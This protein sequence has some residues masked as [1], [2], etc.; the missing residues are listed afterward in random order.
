MRIAFVELSNFRK[1]KATRIEF[2]VRQTLFVGAN[3]SGK[4]S[5]MT[6]LRLFLKERG[7]FTTKDVTLSNWRNINALGDAWLKLSPNEEPNLQSL[8]TFLPA[9]DVWLEVKNA[10]LH[11]VAHLLPSLDWNGGLIGVRLRLEPD[12]IEKLV[13]EYRDARQKAE[14]QL[15][16][17]KKKHGDA[18]QDFEL[19]PR[20]LHDFFE[21]RFSILNLKAYPLDPNAV[22]KP[23]ADNI[24]LP[25]SLPPLAQALDGNPLSHLIHIR[26][27]NAQRGF[28]DASSFSRGDEEISQSSEGGKNRLSEQLRGFYKRHLDPTNDPSDEDVSALGAFHRAQKTFDE[29]L[30]QGFQS[31]IGELEKLG[32]PGLTNPKLTIVTRIT[33][34]N[35]LNHPSAVQYALNDC[36]HNDGHPNKLPEDYNGLGFQNL[37][38]MVFRLIRFRSDWMQVGKLQQTSAILDRGVI[39]P[40]QLV[41]VEE[42]E[43][44]LH[45]QVQ[46][47]FARKA[48]EVLRNH[49]DLGEHTTFHT[50]LIVSTHSSHIAHEVDFGCLRYF[51]RLPAIDLMAVPNAV[52]ANLSTVFGDGSDTDRFVARY[53]RTTHCDLFFADGVILIEGT[54]ERM[55]VPQFIRKGYPVLSEHYVSILEIGGSHAH[56]LRPLIELL[57][58]PT[59]IITDLD[60]ISVDERKSVR[61][62]LGTK[63]QTANSVLKTWLPGIENLDELL[64]AEANRTKVG[65]GHGIVH[66]AFQR[67]VDVEFPNGT[68]TKGVIPSTFE[69]AFVLTNLE[70][71][72]NLKG[73]D[74]KDAVSMTKGFLKFVSEAKTLGELHEK[75]FEILQKKSADKAGFALDLLTLPK[76][77]EL[78]PP[79]YIS[80]GLAWLEK[81]M[82]VV[83]DVPRKLEKKREND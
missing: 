40:L 23:E 29:K 38:S 59:L 8:I 46:Q 16:G 18:A 1:L 70:S 74:L 49:S 7:G 14:V 78:L 75:L 27:I 67:P 82:Q 24:A 61:P 36:K 79:L 73:D 35:V 66:V 3:N 47:V 41:L 34:N 64:G 54:A 5:A 68:T 19:W 37:I 39:E 42:P 33:P 55:L 31:A 63:Q 80:E 51:K 17:Y 56:R 48:Y 77:E 43:A 76:L 21:K 32:Y 65:E 9:L 2:A 53:L 13:S 4:T 15:A 11:H 62:Q 52:I 69:D 12:D 83:V 60:A 22:T 50:Q 71:I 6:A 28:S 26:E 30:A 20:S 44:H 81:K 57:G 45:A 58:L 10:E 25:Q 72:K